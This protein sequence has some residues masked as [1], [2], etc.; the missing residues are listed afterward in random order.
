MNC[1]DSPLQ[2]VFKRKLRVSR[3]NT[4]KIIGKKAMQGNVAWKVI[5][6]P[7]VGTSSNLADYLEASKKQTQACFSD[8]AIRLF[9][10]ERFSRRWLDR[11]LKIARGGRIIIWIFKIGTIISEQKTTKHFSKKSSKD[12][13]DCNFKSSQKYPLY[14]W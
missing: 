9:S 7:T 1:S 13:T 2:S 6:W 4:S 12:F 14:Q 3:K 11:F 10:C 8:L 5:L